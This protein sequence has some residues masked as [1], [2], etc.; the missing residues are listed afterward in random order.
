MKIINFIV[1]VILFGILLFGCGGDNKATTNG[2]SDNPQYDNPTGDICID[3]KNKIRNN[4]FPSWAPYRQT[5][6]YQI[7]QG[8]SYGSRSYN[9]SGSLTKESISI[10]PNNIDIDDNYNFSC[11]GSA[12][13]PNDEPFDFLYFD[14]GFSESSI[15]TNLENAV[16]TFDTITGGGGCQKI[17]TSIYRIT[18]RH[19]NGTPKRYIDINFGLPNFA[20]PTLYVGYYG[21]GYII[22]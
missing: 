12:C 11:S 1:T 16:N 14:L 6:D 7:I 15:I 8:I 3:L 4:S 10:N 2:V 17:G 20:N 5:Y 21:F 18:E 9:F 19:D 22:Q 13:P